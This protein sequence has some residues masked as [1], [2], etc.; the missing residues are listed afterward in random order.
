MNRVVKLL[1]ITIA[2]VSLSAGVQA[3]D[4]NSMTLDQLLQ[5]VKQGLH[6]QSAEDKQRI[7][8][9]M[10]DKAKQQQM[11][12]QAKKERAALEAKSTSMEHEFDANET[13]IGN[14]NDTLNKRLGSLKELFGVLQQADGDPAVAINQL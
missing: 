1:L 11:L 3:Q 7:Q 13:Q 5:Q 12:D 2:M 4:K 8:E 10:Q 14:L 9:F 6:E